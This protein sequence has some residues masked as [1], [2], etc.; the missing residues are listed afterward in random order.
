[1]INLKNA[2]F[3]VFKHK[4]VITGK[5]VSKSQIHIGSGEDDERRVQ[6]FIT[7]KYEDRKIPYIPGSSL[8]GVFRST[9]G[10]I[11]SNDVESYLFGSNDPDPKKACAAH[12]KIFDALPINWQQEHIPLYTKPGVAIDRRTGAA[13]PGML[14]SIEVLPPEIKFEFRMIL[15]N[16]DLEDRNDMNRAAIRFLINELKNGY[17]AIGAK[18]TG[19]LGRVILEEVQVRTISNEDIKQD[20]GYRELKDW[21]VGRDD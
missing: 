14:F 15:E 10:Q 9:I 1:M 12:V 20:K 3:N 16:I 19:G 8:K 18:T 5:L 13:S 11:Y 17:V 6:L 4:V 21:E 7:F 2:N